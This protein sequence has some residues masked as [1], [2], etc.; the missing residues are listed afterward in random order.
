MQTEP[1]CGRPLHFAI[2]TDHWYKTAVP[3][4]VLAAQVANGEFKDIYF[5]DN[6]RK[7]PGMDDPFGELFSNMDMAS[8]SPYACSWWYRTE[9]QLPQ[10]F[11]G[12]KLW[13]HFNGINYKANV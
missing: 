4:T 8:G 7:L 3:S 9:F 12:R 11:H 6:I 2:L 5:A 13:L 10:D 1:T